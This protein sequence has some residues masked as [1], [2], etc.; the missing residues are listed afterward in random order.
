MYEQGVVW[1]GAD[2]EYEHR[3]VV[4]SKELL[5][6]GATSGYGEVLALFV[7]LEEGAGYVA[8]GEYEHLVFSALAVV[9]LECCRGAGEFSHLFA[10]PRGY[11]AVID[12]DGEQRVGDAVGLEGAHRGE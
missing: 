8:L 6:V 5:L 10:L 9:H 12:G 1:C 11:D 3:A 2:G 4:E 7:A